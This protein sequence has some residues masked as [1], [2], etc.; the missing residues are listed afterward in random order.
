MI[1][2][3]YEKKFNDVCSH[4]LPNHRF[5]NLGRIYEKVCSK[6]FCSWS[7]LK[8]LEQFRGL[9]CRDGIPG[10][11]SKAVF[12]IKADLLNP[13]NSLITHQDLKEAAR[14]CGF[15]SDPYSNPIIQIVRTH[16]D[17]GD[18]VEVI[19]HSN[20]LI[21]PPPT[22]DSVMQNVKNKT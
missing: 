8:E 2:I 19:E 7:E 17:D 6:K 3:W 14:S 12:A 21:D 11:T 18:E 20:N 13:Q 15:S 10:K 1:L 9:I 5:F 4:S 22:Y 16:V